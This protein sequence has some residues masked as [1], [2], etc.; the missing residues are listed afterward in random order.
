[1]EGLYALDIHI[2]NLSLRVGFSCSVSVH[3]RTPEAKKETNPVQISETFQGAVINSRLSFHPRIDPKSPHKFA[4]SVLLQGSG[5]KKLVGSFEID[6]SDFLKAYP[7]NSEVVM[8]QPLMNCKDPK[9][10]LTLSLNLSP[11]DPPKPQVV[12]AP[13]YAL[14]NQ[15]ESKSPPYSSSENN[16]SMTQNSIM[17]PSSL[18]SP[19]LVLNPA[20]SLNPLSVTNIS[21]YKPPSHSPN[22]KIKSTVKLN[23]S[24]S[25]QPSK[26]SLENSTTVSAIVEDLKKD[27]AESRKKLESAEKEK[28]EL[29]ERIRQDSET[30]NRLE[31]IAQQSNNENERLANQ[32][33]SISEDL[34]RSEQE[35]LALSNSID[36]LRAQI[37][38]LESEKKE[39]Q[40]EVEK[41]ESDLRRFELENASLKQELF[42]AK[43][44]TKSSGGISQKEIASPNTEIERLTKENLDLRAQLEKTRFDSQTINENKELQKA[45]TDVHQRYKLLEES[46]KN[47]EA[48]NLTEVR[49]LQE[50][51]T[52]LEQELKER[53]AKADLT[54]PDPQANLA[55]LNKALSERDQAL[56]EKESLKIEVE[57]S[58]SSLNEAKKV[59]ESLRRELM[60]QQDK[61]KELGQTI[62]RLKE[63]LEKAAQKESLKGNLL[64]SDVKIDFMRFREIEDQNI[65]Y[66]AEIERLNLALSEANEE[67]QRL[68]SIP[69]MGSE[70][71]MQSDI[72]AILQNEN[73]SLKKKIRTLEVKV[74]DSQD[75]AKVKAQ[76]EDATKEI[77]SL[78][79]QLAN[80]NKLKKALE[81]SMED[82]KEQSADLQLK[83]MQ[84]SKRIGDVL[85][86]VEG[87]N[88]PRAQRDKFDAILFD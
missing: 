50:K 48:S 15:I 79:D 70:K 14:D 39:T 71:M 74:Q 36:G 8:T 64:V 9:A 57:R 21:G 55:E 69:S 86:L 58:S 33:S 54:L 35:K 30:K 65:Q 63:D 2:K 49:S 76:Y 20:S 25:P 44:N 83:N 29:E 31:E 26:K 17:K 5:S 27:L 85:T 11:V 18:S 68:K 80:L 47:K 82:L 45:L 88:L 81:D 23:F 22:T 46:S 61:V 87:M 24:P 66:S 1:M 77:A 37:G 56:K 60:A 40:L 38:K 34:I 43:E 73:E 7:L 84:H 59:E 13:S 4:F 28:A 41:L 42:V 16:Q 3:V 51:L 67:I 12:P 52:A 32:I 19:S 53:N 6:L 78:K 10:T 62:E 75:Y 72:F